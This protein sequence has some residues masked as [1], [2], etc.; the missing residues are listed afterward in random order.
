M[1]SQILGRFTLASSALLLLLSSVAA[2]TQTVPGASPKK[3]VAV[4]NFDYGTVRTDVAQ[5]FGGDQDVG[6]GLAD[7]LVAKFVKD[8]SY[9]VVERR[10]LNKVIAEQ[11][12]SNSD[13]SDTTAATKIGRLLSVDAIIVGSITQFGRDD[14]TTTVGA[15]ALGNVTNRF[16]IGGLQKRADRAMVGITARLVD[17]GTGE[18]LAVAEGKGTSTRSGTSLLGGG[19]AGAAGRGSYDMSSSNFG[20]TLLGEAANQAIANLASQLQ[21]SAQQLPTRTVAI[22]GLVADVSGKT[23]ILNVGTKAGVKVGDQIEI[24]H[25]IRE[26]KDP[27]TGKV[28]R[29]IE[30]K[31]GDVAITEV[32]ETSAVGTFTGSVNATVGDAAKGKLSAGVGLPS[33]QTAAGPLAAA[34]ALSPKRPGV[35]RL[36]VLTPQAQM[37]EPDSA[38]SSVAESIRILI[39]QSLTGPTVEVTPIAA[40][41]PTEIEVEAKQKSCDYVLYSS[42][43]QKRSGGMGLL[44]K[45]M[46][47]ANFLPPVAMAKGASALGSAMAAAASA[48]A[49]QTAAMTAASTVKAKNEVAFDYK[50]MAASSATPVLANTA[51][52]KA[53]ADGDDVISPLIQQAAA[54]IVAEVNKKK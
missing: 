40:V 21:M 13:R 18:I 53:K 42:I 43:T 34:A 17:A 11:N 3:R 54:S 7:L 26:I 38:S 49:A 27:A 2:L 24:L 41:S 31:I 20:Q 46:P 12:L 33:A 14:K 36:G 47:V 44:N 1:K 51:K 37:G 35:V 45:A 10:E 6:R 25:K 32:D 5:I 50:L 23:V 15:T 4:M 22:E 39:I 29:S 52:A 9:A 48:Q 19:G 8:G 30:N 28:I 16:G